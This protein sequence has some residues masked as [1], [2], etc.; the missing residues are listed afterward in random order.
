MVNPITLQ[1]HPVLNDQLNWLPLKTLVWVQQA[2]VKNT[3]VKMQMI[4]VCCRGQK[5]T[6]PARWE[7]NL[8]WILKQFVWLCFVQDTLE[9]GFPSVLL[10]PWPL[11][12]SLVCLSHLS[13]CSR[14]SPLRP[15]QRPQR[16][17]P[18]HQ[19]HRWATQHRNLPP[20]MANDLNSLTNTV[21]QRITLWL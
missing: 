8:K 5:K 21:T 20:I 16:A 13:S 4:K 6:M 17:R 12:A 10:S 3:S 19:S 9:R 18:H 1:M 15:C 11:S 7:G 14:T 2:S